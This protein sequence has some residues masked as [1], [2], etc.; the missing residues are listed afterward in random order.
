MYCKLLLISER[1]FFTWFVAS[2][3]NRECE[4]L[5][6]SRY[7]IHLTQINC[8]D[9]LRRPYKHSVPVTRVQNFVLRYLSILFNYS[10]CQQ[11]GESIVKQVFYQCLGI[12]GSLDVSGLFSFFR[13]LS[14]F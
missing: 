10:V 11:T 2:Y 1:V 5:G 8:L 12:H 9:R 6:C 13:D 3:A 14:V 4:N 7:V